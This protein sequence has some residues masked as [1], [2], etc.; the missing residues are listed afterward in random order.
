MED[1]KGKFQVLITHAGIGGK[2]K[3]TASDYTDEETANKWC[4]KIWLAY[5][6]DTKFMKVIKVKENLETRLNIS[7][8]FELEV[9]RSEDYACRN[10]QPYWKL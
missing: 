8:L 1:L 4:S 7:D 5:N 3:F 6:S 9:I 10:F 2:E